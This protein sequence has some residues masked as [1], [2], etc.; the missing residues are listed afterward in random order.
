[1]TSMTEPTPTTT[2][3]MTQA[4]TSAAR[5]RTLAESVPYAPLALFARIIIASIFWNSGRTKVEGLTIKDQTYFLFQHEYALPLIDHRVAAV[6]ATIAEHAFPVL[7]VLGLATRLSALALL[8]MT[9]TIQ[10]FVYPEAWQTHGLWAVSLLLLVM[11]GGGWLS[12][13]HWLAKRYAN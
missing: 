9:L 3:Y 7:L 11:H 12:A 10:I 6:L 13:D 5:L 8:V 1:M 4:R 2:R